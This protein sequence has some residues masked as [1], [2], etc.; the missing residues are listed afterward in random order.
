M[1]PLVIDGEN[2]AVRILLM[3]YGGNYGISVKEMKSIMDNS[4]YPLYPDWVIKEADNEI[5][6]TKAGLQDWIRYLF[7][8]ENTKKASEK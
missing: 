4:S 6:L 5:H 3:F 7:A 8:L 2:K 1:R